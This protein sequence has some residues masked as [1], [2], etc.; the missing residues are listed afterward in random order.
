MDIKVAEK[1]TDIFYNTP[2]NIFL[3]G[4]DGKYLMANYTY[5]QALGLDNPNDILGKTDLELAWRDNAKIYRDN[6]LFVITNKIAHYFEEDVILP[7]HKIKYNSLKVS[8]INANKKV[9]AAFGMCIQVNALFQHQ[10]N[11]AF[12]KKHYNKQPL[13]YKEEQISKLIAQ[14]KKT[15]EIANILGISAGTI[16]WHRHNINEKIHLKSLTTL[17]IANA[18]NNDAKS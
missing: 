9:I 5:A 8:V 18:I 14:G 1:L 2:C 6:D 13:T 17:A 15:K 4:L 10:T 16:N 12:S 11:N 3:K 7:N